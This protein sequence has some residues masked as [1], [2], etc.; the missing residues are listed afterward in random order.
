MIF[1]IMPV[2]TFTVMLLHVSQ[3]PD[4]EKNI[5]RRRMVKDFTGQYKKKLR[6]PSEAVEVVKSGDWID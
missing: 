4:R 3:L 5:G 6:T 2:E 1:M